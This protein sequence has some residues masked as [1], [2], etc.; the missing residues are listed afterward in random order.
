MRRPVAGELATGE[1]RLELPL[2]H[3][4]VDDLRHGRSLPGFFELRRAA[5]DQIPCDLTHGLVIGQ[6]IRV[7]D[8]TVQRLVARMDPALLAVH[9]HGADLGVG[10]LLQD[11]LI[12]SVQ[13][14]IGRH[15][16]LV[17]ADQFF[18]G[19]AGLR[20]IDRQG[21]RRRYEQSSKKQRP[22][23]GESG[24]HDVSLFQRPAGSA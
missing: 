19:R 22:Y 24:L 6:R 14:G 21:G 16:F 13:L 17:R 11:R 5:A 15:R 12:G 10:R 1:L 20:T 8:Q 18:D 3:R 23:C 2:L 9:Q 7:R 4:A